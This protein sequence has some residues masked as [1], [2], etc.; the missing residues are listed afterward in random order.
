MRIGRTAGMVIAMLAVP[1]AAAA[2]G[3]RAGFFFGYSD[4]FASVLQ[5]VHLAADWTPKQF[6]P[7]VD[8]LYLVG[9]FSF[10]KGD[11][12]GVNVTR[13]TVS[14]GAR[15]SLLYGSASGKK[16]TLD[17][18]ALLGGVLDKD[19]SNSLAFVTGPRF[20]YR[21]SSSDR[22]F[23]AV[24]IRTHV[25]YVVRKGGDFWRFSIGPE[26]KLPK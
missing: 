18:H 21:P 23:K 14:G 15:A 11:H 2:D 16:V 9:D 5:G 1:V 12:D 6:P 7:K 10:H 8:F 25:D 4:A 26:W 20:G 3:H 22:G 19:G 24:V 13:F 17:A